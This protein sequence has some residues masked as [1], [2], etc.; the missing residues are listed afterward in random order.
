MSSLGKPDPEQVAFLVEMD[1][2]ELRVRLT[3]YS[4]E[5]LSARDFVAALS[6]FVEDYRENPDELFEESVEFA[7]ERHSS[8][9]SL[10]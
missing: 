1:E 9:S 7:D 2:D 8:I 4:G 3:L 6:V 10:Y 5:R